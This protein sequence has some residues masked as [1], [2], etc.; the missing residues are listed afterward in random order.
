MIS[1]WEI[2]S[3]VYDDLIVGNCVFNMGKGE[4]TLN[5]ACVMGCNSRQWGDSSG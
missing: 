4:F 2:V 3:L 1:K 5:Y